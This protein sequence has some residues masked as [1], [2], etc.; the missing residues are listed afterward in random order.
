MSE[1]TIIT[2]FVATGLLIGWFMH[3]RSS[4][5]LTSIMGRLAAE[6][7]GVLESGTFLRLP[8]LLLSHNGKKMEISAASSGKEGSSPYTYVLFQDVESA[9]LEFRILPKSA[10]TVIDGVL[11]LKKAALSGHPP[12]DKSLVIYTN[13]EDALGALLSER[14]QQALLGWVTKN[15]NRI[16]DI[17]I[18]DKKLIFCVDGILSDT[19]DFR[20]LID[21][22]CLLY[23][24]LDESTNPD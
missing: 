23:D 2:L 14:V 22:A 12:L 6:K 13:D 10:Q 3:G 7:N 16:Q 8:K 1:G 18:H 15:R 21:G 9:G 24:A 5:T 19:A 20:Q 17:R 4:R 11:G